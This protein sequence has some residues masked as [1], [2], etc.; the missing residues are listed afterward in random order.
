MSEAP[1]IKHAVLRPENMKSHDRGVGART[2][3]LVLP[4]MGAST[5][6]NGI[7]EFAPKNACCC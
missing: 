6:I 1:T 2:T 4:S 3:P 5:F 7:T